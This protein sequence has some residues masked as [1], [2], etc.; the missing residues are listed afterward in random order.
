[1]F[2]MSFS[3]YSWNHGC[4]EPPTLSSSFV[5]TVKEAHCGRVVVALSGQVKVHLFA[6]R[7]VAL[8]TGLPD[9]KKG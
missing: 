7:G 1:M 6:R 9:R 2:V 3:F 5:Q 4:Q 8:Q